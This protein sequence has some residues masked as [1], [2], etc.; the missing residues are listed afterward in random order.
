M[1]KYLFVGLI[2]PIQG[3]SLES[4]QRQPIRIQADKAVI[5][6]KEGLSVY[7]G[8]VII[9]QGTLQINAEIVEIKSQD[10]T[11]LEVRARSDGESKKLAKLK[12]TIS[13]EGEEIFE[14]A[15]KINYR[16]QEGI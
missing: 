14:E 6:D 12:Q 4:D 15:N 1:F 5:T 8:N 13:K 7:E 2:F 10:K 9:V 3:N 11:I 16:V